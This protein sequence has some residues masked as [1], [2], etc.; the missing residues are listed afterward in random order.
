MQHSRK[1][2]AP[3]CGQRFERQGRAHA[4]FPAHGYSEQCPH[5]EESFQGWSEGRRQFKHRVR[6]DINHQRDP[7]AK[8]VGHQSEQKRPYWT[9]RQRQENR[10]RDGGNFCLELSRNRADTEVQN[11]EVK[12]VERPAQ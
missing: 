12:S 10:L 7:A 6:D 1:E 2:S 11:E 3:F 8:A 5:D 9:H 4:P